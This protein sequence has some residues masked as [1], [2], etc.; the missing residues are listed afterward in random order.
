MANTAGNARDGKSNKDPQE[1]LGR[2]A[3]RHFP[4]RQASFILQNV[5]KHQTRLAGF[6][7]RILSMHA[8]GMIVRAIQVHVQELNGTEVS[9][10]L[11]SSVTNAVMDEV[12]AKAWQA[13][14]LDAFN[15]MV[16]L[17]CTYVNTRDSSLVWA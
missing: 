15:P 16:Y 4:D 9:L 17:D 6:D 3:H 10:K 13:R 5:P 2:S 14:S 1:R 12:K 11:I 7:G 8:R